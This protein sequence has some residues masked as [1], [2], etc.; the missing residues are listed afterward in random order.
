MGVPQ[1]YWRWVRLNAVGTCRVQ[2][3]ETA[4]A[5]M[6]QQF[7]DL[8]ADIPDRLIQR[9]LMQLLHE[10]TAF[11]TRQ[12]GEQCLRCYISSQIEQVCLELERKFGKP[13]NFTRHDLLPLVLN[14]VDCRIPLTL[15]K[16][17]SDTYQPLAAKILQSFDPDKSLLST[18]TKRIVLYDKQLN[19]FLEE[20]GIW[21]MTDWAILNQTRPGRLARLLSDRFTPD[22]IQ[23]KV[24]LLQSY[25]AIYRRDR[26]QHHQAGQRCLPPTPK[27]LQQMEQ[28]LQAQGSSAKETAKLLQELHALARLLRSTDHIVTESIDEQGAD[29][30]RAS[31]SAAEPDKLLQI[32]FQTFL[33]CLDRAIE[34]TICDRLADLQ[35]KKSRKD[36]AFLTG[37]R[38]FY[39]NLRSM[40]E[41]APMIGLQQQY[42]VAR[43]L[44]LKEL[45]EDV[46]RHT[47]ALMQQEGLKE[48]L[49]DCFNPDR[50][51]QL[52]AQFEAA[53][54]QILD[55]ATAEASSPNR[56]SRTLFAQRFCQCL[57]IWQSPESFAEHASIAFPT[58]H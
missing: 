43:L 11:E 7:P 20:C 49:G 55:Q 28:L 50:L 21:L 36:R 31:D 18:W 38:L 4:E 32:Y 6:Q 51:A 17:G 39:C 44:K 40:G 33:N 29:K 3:L 2:Y 19:A 13:G 10:G 54:N 1:R 37:L 46:R 5:F 45:R 23:Q 9:R 30:Y 26:L 15:G 35:Q 22:E 58:H 56:T 42:Q 25:H 53:V 16:A 27:Q 47:I 41:I 14:D 34:Q 8:T 12:Q 48:Q 52:D 24:L 57:T